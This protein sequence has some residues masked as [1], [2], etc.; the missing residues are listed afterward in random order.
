ML[1]MGAPDAMHEPCRSQGPRLGGGCMVVVGVSFINGIGGQ[2]HCGRVRHIWTGSTP[3]KHC[4]ERQLHV[5][6]GLKPWKRCWLADRPLRV[7]WDVLG[8]GSSQRRLQCILIH[9]ALT[10]FNLAANKPAL[11]TDPAFV[12]WLRRGKLRAPGLGEHAERFMT[13]LHF[14]TLQILQQW[15]N[16][17][18]FI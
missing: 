13:T 12:P 4:N 8:G 5:M 2:A 1:A 9:S 17:L 10:A 15:T 3:P 18:M 14:K 6:A 7:I 16:Y 11:A